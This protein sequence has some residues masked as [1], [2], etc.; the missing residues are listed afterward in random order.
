MGLDPIK[1]PLPVQDVVPHKESMCLLRNVVLHSHE[2]T[3]CD[4]LILDDS[5]FAT[6][7]GVGSWVGVEYMAQAVAAHA[8]MCSFGDAPPR[9]G[10]LLGA[11]KVHLAVPFFERG[12][13]LLIK[14][15]PTWGEG[16]LFSFRCSIQKQGETSP[17][18]WAELNVYRPAQL[19]LEETQ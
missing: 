11:R 3:V 14:V 9:I 10:F 5:L 7:Q 15:Q 8:G 13:L 12:T 17:L 6:K 16:E 4:V 1:L 2:E 18:A 19:P